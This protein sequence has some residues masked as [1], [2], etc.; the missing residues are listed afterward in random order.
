MTIIGRMATTLG[1]L[2]AATAVQAHLAESLGQFDGGLFN[3]T[4]PVVHLVRPEDFGG[5]GQGIQLA[6]PAVCLFVYRVEVNRATRAGWSAVGHHDGRSHLPL[7]IHFL[8]SAL[9]NSPEQELALLG[10][11]AGCL[12][13]QPIFSTPGLDP[14]AG[15]G[16][17]D[18][19]QV[20]FG[21]VAPEVMFRIFEALSATY[22]VSV[23]Y[24]ARIVRIDGPVPRTGTDVAT[25]VTGLMPTVDAVPVP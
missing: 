23:P 18:S 10:M 2:A 17:G 24:V 3:Q 20:Q 5:A 8:I 9:G 4:R 14:A 7:D 16:P 1:V 15:F 19:V 25:V 6:R 22:R 11:A 21:D 12:E 13:D